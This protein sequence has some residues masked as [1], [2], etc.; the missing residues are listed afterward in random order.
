MTEYVISDPHFYHKLMADQRGFANVDKMNYHIIKSINQVVSKH[1]KLYVLG[2]ISFANKEK[3]K[4]VIDQINGK[5]ILVMG[6]HDR[7]GSDQWFYDVGFDTVIRGGLW[8]NGV[9]LTHEP[10][11]EYFSSILN[12]HGHTHEYKAKGLKI[13]VCVEALK[14]IPARLDELIS[15]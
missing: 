5:L 13:N 8:L 6:N 12:I 1:D 7:S 14:Y 11:P 9:L 10:I 15:H 3:T 2:D 4:Y